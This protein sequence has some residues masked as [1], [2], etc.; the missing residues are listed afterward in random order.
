MV[1][2][3]NTT[4]HFTVI[5]CYR[6]LNNVLPP[7]AASIVNAFIQSLSEG[8]PNYL[9]HL[10]SNGSSLGWC[11]FLKSFKSFRA[12][13][14]HLGLRNPY[15]KKSQSVKSG[16]W[17]GH[18]LS[19]RKKTCLWWFQV[20]CVTMHHIAETKYFLLCRPTHWKYRPLLAVRSLVTSYN[21]VHCLLLLCFFFKK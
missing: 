10:W 16:N 1:D 12:Q 2:I 15:R 11:S 20:M 4:C 21:N 13:L 7:L 14:N 3:K 17:K 18:L 8:F 5:I 6:V 19:T 9:S